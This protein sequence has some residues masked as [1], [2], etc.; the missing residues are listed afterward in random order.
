MEGTTAGAAGA[1]ATEEMAAKAMPAA[2][3]RDLKEN[4][5]FEGVWGCF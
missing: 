5:I 3:A 1:A 4:I 2:R